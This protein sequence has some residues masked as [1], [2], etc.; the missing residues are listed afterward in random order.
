MEKF[1]FN[2]T[3]HQIER[4]YVEPTEKLFNKS[5]FKF[6]AHMTDKKKNQRRFDR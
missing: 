1:G 5:I 4:K 6:H 3:K 2:F